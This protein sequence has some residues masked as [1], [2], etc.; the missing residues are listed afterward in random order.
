[1][2]LIVAPTTAAPPEVLVR[3]AERITGPEE[4]NGTD[5]GLGADS[6]R[7]VAIVALNVTVKLF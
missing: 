5:A 1:M 3:F 7:V 2:K 4:P 6:V